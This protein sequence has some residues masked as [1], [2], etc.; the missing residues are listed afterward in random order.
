[1]PRLLVLNPNT[2][3]AVTRRLGA[4]ARAALPGV[5]IVEATGRFGCAYVASRAA[6]AI[7]G[8]AALDAFAAQGADCDAVLL[9]CFGDPGLEALREIAGVPVIGLIEATAQ[10]AGEMAAQAGGQAPPPE[11]RRFAIVTGGERWPAMLAEILRARGLADRCV[12]IRAVAPT[13]G[14]IARDPQAARAILHEAC[15][16][17]IEKDGAQAVILGGAGLVGLAAELQPEIGAPVICSVEAGLRAARAVLAAPKLP[18]PPA[19]REEVTGLSA[20][21]ATRL[22]G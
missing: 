16:D 8:H 20:A 12:G 13:G 18:L 1:M 4:M 19:P 5:D 14:D 15:R 22:R 11:P 6:F 3:E 17:A 2:T 10:E 21:L 9:A 7:A